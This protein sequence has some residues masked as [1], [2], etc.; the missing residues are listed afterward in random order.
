MLLFDS[1]GVGNYPF[2]KVIFANIGDCQAMGQKPLTFV[3]Q[4]LACCVDPMTHLNSEV[5][6]V[7]VRERAERILSDTGGSS[8]GM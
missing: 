3:R 4:L 8:L 6:P 5:Y 1:Q 7:D 2:K